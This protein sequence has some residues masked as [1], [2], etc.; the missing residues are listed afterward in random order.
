MPG[1]VG[2]M[3]VALLMS[4]TVIAAKRVFDELVNVNWKISYLPISPLE[5]VRSLSSMLCFINLGGHQLGLSEHI[6][7]GFVSGW[8]HLGKFS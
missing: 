6:L 2:P 5:K 7:K 8:V 4:N 3:T 1:G